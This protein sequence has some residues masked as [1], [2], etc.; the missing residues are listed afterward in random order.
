[1]LKR[2][3]KSSPTS[4]SKLKRTILIALIIVLLFILQSYMYID[5]NLKTPLTQLAKVR[6]KQIATESIN[7]AVSDRIAQNTNLE[8]LID[9]RTDRNGKVNGFTLNPAEHMK[10]SGDTVQIVKKQLDR[11]QSIPERI[12]LGQAMNSPLLASFG[13]DIPIRL[14]PAGSVKVDLNTRYQNAGI[15]MVV[16]EVY[17]RVSVEISVIIPFNTDPELVET[18]LPISYSLVV[19]DVPTYYFDGKGNPVGPNTPPPNIALPKM[20][21]APPA[22][23]AQKP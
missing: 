8:K 2:R 15:N 1:M 17:V 5:R 10:I 20:D 22:A 21:A 14:V 19:G 4:K 3:W 6:M 7:A 16:V 9:W 18:E 11:L 12:P 13:P 23:N